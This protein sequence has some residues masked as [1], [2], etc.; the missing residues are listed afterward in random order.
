MK[1]RI[2][3]SDAGRRDTRKRMAL[4]GLFFTSS[5]GLLI[6]RC[7]NLHLSS[8]PKLEK[9]ARSQYQAKIDE[10]PPRGNIYDASGEELAISVPTYSLAARPSRLKDLKTSIETLSA[11]LGMKEADIR[12]KMDPAKKYVWVKRFLS[13]QEREQV[14]ALKWPELELVKGAKRFYP[15]R[16]MASQVL[17]AVGGENEGLAGLEL[18]Y[19]RYLQGGGTTSM[20]YRD[21]RGK[22]FETEETLETGAREVHNLHLT[23]RK[24]IQYAAERELDVACSSYRARACTAVVL[25]PETGEI[26]AM[27]SYPGFNANA[28][29]KSN[30]A[31]WRNRAVTD[32]FEPGS[33]FK[34]ILA[35]AGLETN[36]VKPTDR[37]FCENGSLQIGK[38]VIHDHEP[39]G[40]MSFM[41]ILKVSSN[42]GM[43]KI[44]Q[45]VGKKNFA[46]TI[47]NFGFGRKTGVDY[48]GEVPGY[49]PQSRTWQ[50]IEFANLA[51]GQGLRVTAL[52]L[53]AAYAAIAN[54]GILYK[55]YLVS[56]VTDAN[57]RTVME[58]SPKP[59]GRVI[60]EKTAS[61]LLKALEGVVEEGGT[62]T[63]A[64][65]PGYSIAGKTGTAQKVVD[66]KYSHTKFFSSFIG[67]VPADQPRFVVLVSVDEPQGVT[68]GGLVAAPVFR[69]IAWE[70]IRDLAISP[71]TSPGDKKKPVVREA[72]FLNP[73]DLSPKAFDSPEENNFP[74]FRQLSLRKVLSLL[75]SRGL[76]CEVVGSGIV[77][78]QEPLPGDVLAK[79]ERCRIVL[80]A[81]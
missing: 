29:E 39:Y 72:G 53:A 59:V 1:K 49:V 67:I 51:F 81:E 77:V 5:F 79:G 18:Y 36:T 76:G 31:A 26:L 47:Q 25:D 20:A 6:F 27:A 16:E 43:Y 69:K 19:D 40:T 37:F 28:Y 57:D 44:G 7:L 2:Y 41:D 15:N 30:L 63:R 78:G 23:I 45:K 60:G 11:L 9:R 17:G 70:A 61:R 62:A 4:I 3:S 64:A 14:E 32:T 34:T 12:G 55:P 74:D 50:E 71:Q 68:Y 24:N 48:P 10:A 22:T 13:P 42:V 38:H 52:Q 58:I 80:K 56:R 73:Q 21:A 66:G 75:D 54:G 46:E 65:L 35:A 8:D 33:T